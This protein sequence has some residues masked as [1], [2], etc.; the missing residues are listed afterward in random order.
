MQ[1]EVK[2]EHIAL[3][4]PSHPDRNLPFTEPLRIPVRVLGLV[5]PLVLELDSGINSPLLFDAG[6]LR[7]AA[8]AARCCIVAAP[9][10]HR[11]RGSA[12]PGHTGG[13]P[14]LAA[15]FFRGAFISVEA[16]SPMHSPKDGL[17]L[18]CLSAVSMSAC[19]YKCAGRWHKIAVG[20]SGCSLRDP[21][22]YRQL[23]IAIEMRHL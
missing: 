7:T 17:V 1:E 23:E 22:I 15:N 14:L 10:V 20:G 8:F 2:G 13:T 3:A 5:R 21:V 18:R 16:K 9:T 6:K 19:V 11:L 4:T 12:A